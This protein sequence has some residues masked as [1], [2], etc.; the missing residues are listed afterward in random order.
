MW[1]LSLLGDADGVAALLAEGYDPNGVNENGNTA[2]ELAVM[3]EQPR[4]AMLLLR[5]GADASL[6]RPEDMWI[7]SFLGAECF[8]ALL[9]AGARLPP[10]F[11]LGAVTL[12]T[13]RRCERACFFREGLCLADMRRMSPHSHRPAAT[14]AEEVE[15]IEALLRAG[16]DIDAVGEFRATAYQLALEEESFFF[17]DWLEERGAALLCPREGRATPLALAIHRELVARREARAAWDTLRRRLEAHIPRF[18]DAT[19]RIAQ[20]ARDIVRGGDQKAFGP[21]WLCIE[22]IRRTYGERK[23]IQE[24]EQARAE[25]AAEKYKASREESEKVLRG[26]G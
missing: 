5:H 22:A 9:A 20:H 16:V 19:P 25:A 10:D 17:A 12:E 8:I 26:D 4:V 18:H 23:E 3:G 1:D 2:L 11:H 13:Y 14:R 15:M 21:M 6:V 7:A 24:N